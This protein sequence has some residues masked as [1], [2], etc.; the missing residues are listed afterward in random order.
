MTAINI[1]Y[2]LCGAG[3]IYTTM[4]LYGLSL[5]YKKKINQ[6][7]FLICISLSIWTMFHALSITADNV[8]TALTF[9]QIKVLGYGLLYSFI[10][11]LSKVLSNKGEKI[12]K[13]YLFLIYLPSAYF[14]TNYL[15]LGDISKS[16]FEMVQTQQGWDCI[17][18][19]KFTNMLLYIYI[20]LFLFL[21][22]LNIFKWRKNVRNKK[23]IKYS[24]V[25]AYI[26]LFTFI[27][28]VGANVLMS[29]VL[30]VPNPHITSLF[31]LPP[32]A[33]FFYMLLKSQAMLDD[34]LVLSEEDIDE[35][36]KNSILKI[37][38]ILYVVMAYM[39]IAFDYF[40]YNKTDVILIV[41]MTLGAAV[42]HMFLTQ[43]FKKESTR[44]GFLIITAILNNLIIYIRYYD[45][46]VVTMWSLFFCY[47]LISTIFKKSTGTYIL[48]I[49]AVLFQLILWYI[50]PSMELKLEWIDYIIRIIILTFAAVIIIFINRV[51]IKNNL[52]KN[53]Y[54]KY[55]EMMSKFSG[56][57]MMLSIFSDDAEIL[58]VLE[59]LK[60]G[61]YAKK[62]NYIMLSENSKYDIT[63]IYFID[64][65][66]RFVEN[67]DKN[68][69]F[70]SNKILLEKLINKERVS[71]F[72]EEE[73]EKQDVEY[74]D[75]LL[76][77]KISGF[78]AFPI[79]VE[80]SVKAIISFE[81]DKRDDNKMILMYE[82]LL[83][84]ILRETIK[85]FYRERELFYK[86]NRD[87]ITGLY[88]KKYFVKKADD[89]LKL[90]SEKDCYVLYI[91]IDKFKMANDVFGHSVGDLILKL[92]ADKLVRYGKENN[93]LTRFGNDDFIVLCFDYS[94]K[95][96][97]K[98]I[99]D[100][101]L[102]LK[103]GFKID[104][105]QVR[106]NVSI[107]ISKYLKDGLDINT[108]IKNADIAMGQAKEKS[109]IKYHFYNEVDEKRLLEEVKLTEKIYS[110]LLKN[111]FRLAFQPQVNAKT[112]EIIGA[113]VLLRWFND[114]L[115]FVPPNKFI[116][117][118]EKTGLIVEV[119]DWIIEES[120]KEIIEIENKK[121][122][123]IRISVN[124]SAIQFL[125][126][127]LIEKIENFIEKYNI[128]PDYLE[129]EITESVAINDDNFI[130][131]MF[132]NAKKLGVSIAI[133]DFGTGFSSL[134]RLQSLPLDRLKIDK[135]FVDGI[136][137]DSKKEQVVRIVIELAKSLGLRS[138]AE[139]VEE[140]NQ[141][142]YLIDNGCDE[143]QGYY[144]AKPMFKEEF[145]KFI[146]SNS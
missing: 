2:V 13:K 49:S 117:I 71:I 137:N 70:F 68:T 94:K 66:K 115:G 39:S 48:Y 25:L 61:F 1:S 72:N 138:I 77:N 76:K 43:I 90:N 99:N 113:E 33:M 17:T 121:I 100:I 58:S 20:G 23:M 132:T 79:I 120:M 63:K 4:G 11:H 89:I 106:F 141:L 139:G 21:S 36:S 7:F 55:Q 51:Y 8:E 133:D 144:F 67:D 96:I 85:K 16:Y 83:L 73:V 107:G 109:Y 114:E 105:R 92:I 146:K 143:I 78:V 112:K 10:L 91:D 102:S 53:R 44:V 95:E 87:D 60:N 111:E 97:E 31:N 64:D 75:I 47:L 52:I 50:V 131:E 34:K 142:K 129:F 119:G 69:I 145:E 3:C 125:D 122:N 88:S 24:K 101:I 128:N 40:T 62:L 103:N 28:S 126:I 42:I 108:L 19:S 98:F 32:I 22:L 35:R 136:G 14:I 86:A 130:S 124:L 15:L 80:N 59:Y 37:L 30:K 82:S 116:P 12:S 104:E 6:L 110:A 93:I 38:G 140:E 54:I 46:M 57:L 127:T 84:N 135:S 29:M 134:N 5:D 65:N 9:N 18:P 118:L 56:K 26:S 41:V 27:I 45:S 81:F 123:P 74:K